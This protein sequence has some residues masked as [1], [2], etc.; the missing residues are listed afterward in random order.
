MKTTKSK[1]PKRAQTSRGRTKR[2]NYKEAAIEL[3]KCAV[4][5]LKFLDTKHGG[6]MRMLINAD[7]TRSVAP[8]PDTFMAALEKIGYGVD[9]D[10]FWKMRGERKRR[11]L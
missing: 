7:G 8:W 6:G 4:F 5:A 1:K 9:R 2:V 11:R 3:G 10:A